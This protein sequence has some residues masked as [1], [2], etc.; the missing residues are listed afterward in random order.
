MANTHT[1]E[2]AAAPAGPATPPA[3][4]APAPRRQRGHT[5]LSRKNRIGLVLTFLLGL[6]NIPSVLASTPDGDEGPPMG[7]LV[8]DSICGVLM[9]AAVVVAWRTG[10]RGA[11]RLAAGVNILQALSAVPA[12]FVDV[13]VGIKIAASVGVVVSFVAVVL[14]LS[15]GRR[16][17]AVVD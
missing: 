7:V 8:L 17:G 15:P 4:A 2:P 5:S 12:F 10:S 6:V 9:V 11:V 14:T 13:P 16:S 1:P 3:P